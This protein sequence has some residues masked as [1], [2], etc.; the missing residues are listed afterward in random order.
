MFYQNKHDARPI[1]S[2]IIFIIYEVDKMLKP[3]K[4]EPDLGVTKSKQ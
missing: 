4:K 3:F 1:M 2:L